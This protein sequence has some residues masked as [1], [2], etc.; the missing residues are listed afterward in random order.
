[1]DT[2]QPGVRVIVRE[3]PFLDSEKDSNSN[4]RSY[5]FYGKQ[6]DNVS[7]IFSEE[8]SHLLQWIF[9]GSNAT[10]FSYGAT[11]SGKTYTMQ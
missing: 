7:Q 8:I 1:M 5:S 4:P 11:G 2:K 9:Q 6:D 10:V 3:C